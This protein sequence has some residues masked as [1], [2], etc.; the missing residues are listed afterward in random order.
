MKALFVLNGPPNGTEHCYDARR[1]AGASA[2][3]DYLLVF[4]PIFGSGFG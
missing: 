3:A 4:Q 2:E 1:L